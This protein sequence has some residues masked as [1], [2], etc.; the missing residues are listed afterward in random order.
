M[1]FTMAGQGQNFMTL[2]QAKQAL[3]A[4]V[5]EVIKTMVWNNV[6]RIEVKTQNG[7]GMG[8]GFVF[9]GPL[10]RKQVMT[11]YHVVKDHDGVS[12]MRI[13]FFYDG[14]DGPTVTL[15]CDNT[16]TYYSPDGERDEEGQEYD[17]AVLDVD[18]IPE[19]A[20]GI[21]LEYTNRYN[22]PFD[23]NA[24]MFFDKPE[25]RLPRLMNI[26]EGII[27]GHPDGGPKRISTVQFQYGK[28]GDR[29]RVYSREGTRPGSSG[30]PVLV[31]AIH[32]TLVRGRVYALHY[33]SGL[34]INVQHII[35]A[36]TQQAQ[37]LLQE[38]GKS[39]QVSDK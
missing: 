2:T 32:T 18:G 25:N 36:I 13:G 1:Q 39:L 22:L 17:F 30:S 11:N 31:N 33:R 23:A 19:E 34:G 27:V 15:E 6:V 29:D 16:P 24:A 3:D 21:T 9:L 14:G 7:C 5:W 12:P 38:H 28:E 20:M 37:P 4:E 10:N 8:T 35:G 26:N